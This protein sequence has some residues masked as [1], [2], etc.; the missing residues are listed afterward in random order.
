MRMLSSLAA[1][2]LLALSLLGAAAL[3]AAADIQ[4]GDSF[5]VVGLSGAQTMKLMAGPARWAGLT[6]EVPFDAR[7]LRATGVRQ[8]H[9]VQLSYRQTNGYDA[10]GWVESQFLAADDRGEA[11]VY[12]VVNVARRQSVPLMGFDGYGVQARIPGSTTML[13]ACGP[14]QDGYCQ[15]SFK[16]RRGTVEGLVDQT[17]LAIVRP[18]DPG[19]SL[20]E[21]TR[22]A[23]PAP[24]SAYGYM[25]QADDHAEPAYADA[26]TVDLLPPPR[27]HALSWLF[28]N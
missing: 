20:V 9:W 19:F 12:R 1:T 5:R 24:R 11:T 26:P 17:K 27:H 14:C 4:G 28:K 16:T 22:P 8:G 23:Y 6:A 25:V 2:A 21:E 15:V 3:P 13:P 18:A 10:T 7:N